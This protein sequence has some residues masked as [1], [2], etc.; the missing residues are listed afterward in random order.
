MRNKMSINNCYFVYNENL[1]EIEM[2]I[3]LIDTF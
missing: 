3:M 1:Y 2:M